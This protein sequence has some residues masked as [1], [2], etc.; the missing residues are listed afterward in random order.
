M[1]LK[2]NLLR[3]NPEFTRNL[4]LE[5]TIQR[6]IAMPIILSGLFFLIF[7]TVKE[8]SSALNWTLLM[9]FI[10]VSIR[11]TSLVSRSIIKEIR[12]K[13]WDF[14]RMTIINPW[15]MVWG[16]LFGSS[17][18]SWY[19]GII[20]IIVYF[21][22]IFLVSEPFLYFKL[23]I[24]AIIFSLFLQSMSMLS[25]LIG[26]R[27][28]RE[29]GKEGKINHTVFYTFTIFLLIISMT[30]FS[31]PDNN[32]LRAVRWY[33][34]YLNAI[35]L[36]MLT[37]FLFTVWA[38]IGLYRLMRTE[39]QFQN[40]PWIWLYFQCFLFIYFTG[41]LFNIIGLSISGF[42]FSSLIIFYFTSIIL[43]YMATFFD[44]KNIVD[45]ERLQRNIKFKA[46]HELI[47][48]L[49]LWMLS[50][51]VSVLMVYFIVLLIFF[52]DISEINKLPINFTEI[53]SFKIAIF[54]LSI[55]CFT[56]RDISIL[57]YLGFS[58]RNRNEDLLSIIF[59]AILYLLVPEI[60]HAINLD[61]LTSFFYPMLGRGLISGLFP[62]LIEVVIILYFLWG[63][64]KTQINISE[65]NSE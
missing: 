41:F 65:T 21:S 50:L 2:D 39:L 42:I 33:V 26:I 31:W 15:S 60:L 63:Q 5:L 20:I 12:S 56:I 44:S 4:W 58:R 40:T 64:I 55:L 7:Y 17:I 16:K 45:Y 30:I 3:I 46:Y 24:L 18:H 37:I 62:I 53:T 14:Q 23:G 54:C 19:G 57:M 34:F 32:L 28:Y 38:F 10:L 43:T 25:A 8:V 49:P 22:C 36:T 35:D 47:E 9:Y 6:L 27:S 59:L 13:T 29:N 11:G 61:G 48:D 52:I 1:T 51:L